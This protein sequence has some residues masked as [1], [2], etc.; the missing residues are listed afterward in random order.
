MTI[1]IHNH[2]NLATVSIENTANKTIFKHE[3]ISDELGILVDMSNSYS[4]ELTSLSTMVR[5]V[6][7]SIAAMYDG[8]PTKLI[9]RDTSNKWIEIKHDGKNFVN[10]APVVRNNPLIDFEAK[11][12][13]EIIKHGIH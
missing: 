13:V 1:Q 8:L 9:Y 3:L 11:D 7:T 2:D 5:P 10:F 12:V 4:E 6:V